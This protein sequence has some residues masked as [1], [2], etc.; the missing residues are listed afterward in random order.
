VER[1]DE[2]I[3]EALD[4]IIRIRAVQDYSPSQAVGF[5]FELK[6][7]VHEELAGTPAV[8]AEADSLRML[9]V[10]VDR[11]ALQAFDVY[12]QCREQVYSIRVNEIRNRSLKMMERL[13]AWRAERDDED[14]AELDEP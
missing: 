14:A 6:N 5:V 7:L 11:L 4:R 12:M 10:R 13:N 2:E 3:G 9:D 8:T 1:P